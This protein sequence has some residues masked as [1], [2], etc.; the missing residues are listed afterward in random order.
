MYERCLNEAERMLAADKDIIVP[1]KKLWTEVAKAGSAHPF[2]VPGLVDFTA[3][4]EGD[5]RFEFV[6]S[7]NSIVDDLEGGTDADKEEEE[8][9]LENLGF[10][11]GDR[12]KLRRLQL[13]PEVLGEIIRS[14]VDRTMDALTKAWELRPDGDR[15]TED[16]LLEILSRTQ[17]LQKEVRKTFSPGRMKR[18]ARALKRKSTS[19]KPSSR[20]SP[21]PSRRKKAAPPAA[22]KRTTKRATPKRGTR[23]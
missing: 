3:L 5:H 4:L 16:T 19:A 11:S 18:V 21:S 6:A 8:K 10:F 22:R 12:V 7:H 14:K 20:K 2:E 1:V 23:R 15:E 9:E 17:H 13:S